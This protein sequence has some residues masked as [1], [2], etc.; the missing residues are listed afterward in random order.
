[1]SAMCGIELAGVSPWGGLLRPFRPKEGA[2]GSGLRGF[3]PWTPGVLPLEWGFFTLGISGFPLG[4]PGFY[5]RLDSC[6]LSGRRRGS[7]SPSWRDVQQS[8]DER[9]NL[10]EMGDSLEDGR[11]RTLIV[12]IESVADASLRTADGLGIQLDVSGKQR[13]KSFD[14]ISILTSPV[15]SSR[16]RA[17]RPSGALLQIT[18]RGRRR[19][20]TS[21]SAIRRFQF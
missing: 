12:P 20:Q 8:L 11:E 19:L 5:P 18:R 3:Y 21:P 16:F 2:G 14:G 4:I 17:D 9:A 7:S 6:G 10:G 13:A 1:M 15:W